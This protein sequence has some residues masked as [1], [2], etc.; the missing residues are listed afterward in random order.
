MKPVKL[1]LSAFGPYAGRTEIDFERFGGQG[2]YLIT[3]DTGAGKTTLF[4]AI[5][6]AL[7]GEAS[8]DVRK[9]DMFRSKYARPDVPTFVEFSF[10]YRGK[11][12]LVKRSPEYMR[13]KGR[14]T[15]YTLQRAEAELI[16]P[17][18]REPVTKSREVT[19]AVTELIG[20]E[21]RQFTQIA[22]IA[23]G[24]FQKLLLAG[25][26]ERIGIFRQIFKTGL[27]Q[28]L[29]EQLKAAEKVQW[30]VYDELKRSM[31]QYMDSIICSGDTPLSQQMRQLQKGKFDGRIGEGMQILEQLCQEDEA[32][33]RELDGKIEAAE[34]Q[35]QKDDQLL[36]N[37]HKVMQQREELAKNQKLFEIQSPQ[38]AL[39]KE[40]Y[41]RAG[42]DAEQCAQIALQIKDQQ[43]HLALFTQLE[44]EKDMQSA[45]EEL[46]QE[47]IIH[48]QDLE[49]QKQQLEDALKSDAETLQS[50]ADAGEEKERLENRQNNVSRDQRSLVQ[51]KE[52]LQQAV[53]KHQNI[54]K[55]KKEAA[56]HEDLAR[57]QIQ[58]LQM[59]IDS[60]AD[61]DGMLLSA[62]EI[63]QKLKEQK[64][65]LTQ[66]AAEQESVKQETA[67]TEQIQLEL[68]TAAENLN[69]SVQKNRIQREQLQNASET[70]LQ[71]RHQTQEAADRLSDFTEQNVS[72]TK[73]EEAYQQ[74]KKAYEQ[75]KQQAE[76]HQKQQD[77]R[78]TEWEETKGAEFELLKLDQKKRELKEQKKIYYELINQIEIYEKKQENLLMAQ[79]EYSKAIREKEERGRR[80]Q[81]LERLFLDAR[82]GMLAKDLEEGEACPV[83][84]SLHHPKPAK[85]PKEVPDQEELEQ[86]KER[87]AQAATAA[88]R[89]SAEA[90]N[91][92]ERLAEQKQKVRELLQM[93]FEEPYASE[94]DIFA[95]IQDDLQQKLADRLQLLH[96]SEKELAEAAAKAADAKKRKEE[97]D[98]IL[99]DGEQKLQ[100]LNEQLRQKSQDFAAVKGQLEEKKNR[101]ENTI[102]ML[103]FPENAAGNKEEM[104]QYL[105]QMLLQ[106]KTRLEQA[107][108]DKK[109]LNDL[110][111]EAL[112]E[113]T[114]RQ[115]LSRQMDDAR[116]LLADLS[117]QDKA[118]QKQIRRDMQK[119]GEILHEADNFINAVPFTDHKDG[120]KSDAEGGR[121]CKAEL[122]DRLAIDAG[123]ER[124]HR[125]ELPEKLTA[126]AEE[127][128]QQKGELPDKLTIDAGEERRHKAEL[129][130]KLTINA[131]G[132]RQC[133]A[134][135]PEKLTANAEEESRQKGELPDKLS[136]A[137]DFIERLSGCIEKITAEIEKR[138]ALEAEK[139]LKAAHLEESRTLLAELEKDLEVAKNKRA[140]S[141]K[142]LNENLCELH[143]QYMKEYKGTAF[144]EVAGMKEYKGTAFTEVTG[145][146]GYQGAAFTEVTGQIEA[147][148]EAETEKQT[149]ADS[150]FESEDMAALKGIAVAVMLGETE[151]KVLI[152]KASRAEQFLAGKLSELKD[153]LMKNCEKLLM[154]QQLEEQKPLKET[155]LQNFVRDI[156]NAE[157]ALT[158]RKTQNQARSEKIDG[159]Q[160]QL[161]AERKEQAEEKIQ[162]L[163]IKKNQLEEAFKQAQQ[164]YTDCSTK[165]ERISASIETL[166][167]QLGSAGEAGTVQEE[168]VLKR[169]DQQLKE[170]KALRAK[171]DEK[172]HAYAVNK[173][174]YRKITEK[175]A[176]IIDVEKKYTWMHALSETANGRLSGKPK[177][178]LET[179]IQMAYFDRIL[180]RASLR[181]LTMSS[182][183]YELKRAEE[184]GNLKGKE[185]LEICVIDHYNATERS[186]KTLSGG[187]SFEA[188][189]SLALGLSDEIQSYAG[190]IQMD[191]M[192]VDEGFG[193]LDEEA[194]GQAMKALLRLTEGNRLVGVISHVAELK[195]QIDRKIIVTKRRGTDGGVNS[196]ADIE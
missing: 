29:Q 71:C 155:K 169:K 1:I 97:L 178:E 176:D 19:R 165:A 17:D 6:F 188:S 16:Y 55:Q 120:H 9:A 76:E 181:L 84:G 11:R 52:I 100:A 123:E 48:K 156:Q 89:L 62:K 65:V 63:R 93:L 114:D 43:D 125:A 132:E 152:E 195:E 189:L 79:S 174:I 146:K 127:E 69:Q 193:S 138:T 59:Q 56:R 33:V 119:T 30:K 22:M 57:K 122:L 10:D 148:K 87:L 130:E 105:Q 117:G 137:A 68:E 64:E 102:T 39:A 162:A 147:E 141:Q 142:K 21:R 78:R 96:E 4:D 7:Y 143:L 191:A 66:E 77:L 38:L 53:I 112:K 44:Q 91:L 136:A 94:K 153:A 90:G 144:T 27:Y 5:V 103:R 150:I 74:Q 106:C 118:L 134:E 12:Y 46:L 23:Q 70:E 98:R 54:Q 25:T 158:K 3:G 145:M 164:H 83:C 186:V 183:Q 140:E 35:M 2:L 47:E 32:A 73:S 175:Q 82:A 51:Q 196:F 129:P 173:D 131:E 116:K 154:K 95:D 85:V 58:H 75:T 124:H 190:G 24:D 45:Q 72:L 157:V 86:E 110:E 172:N 13:P 149:E 81:A 49:R 192:F 60:M 34:I 20:I 168:T 160:K 36:G 167:N 128:R 99:K 177:I 104:Q 194:L 37:I 8:G 111:K 133:K 15:G 40:N 161:G 135:Q 187:E 101:W 180:R 14:G 41:S 139:Q 108:A 92:A 115:H 121:Q 171:R 50:L 166:K 26:E 113:E 184:S 31:N 80:C 159:L 42:E 18:G 107:E 185:G 67:Q 126:N 109:R 163:T 179:Y 170:K 151:E 28:K 61:W 88:E 182:G